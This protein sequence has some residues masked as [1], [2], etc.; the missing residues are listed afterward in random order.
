MTCYS[1]PTL[2]SSWQ[3]TEQFT[4]YVLIVMLSDRPTRVVMLG[5]SVCVWWWGGV[6]GG[7]DF[8]LPGAELPTQ[9]LVMYVLVTVFFFFFFFFFF[10]FGRGAAKFCALAF[11][12][13]N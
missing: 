13:E 8:Q 3:K 12:C 11:F 6:R 2:T 4:S 9:G 1:S 10:C 7:G 5:V